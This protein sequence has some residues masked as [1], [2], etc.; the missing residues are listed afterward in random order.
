MALTGTLLADF[1][2]FNDAVKQAEVHLKSFETGAGGV[3]K[4]LN[5][6]VD[7][8]SGRKLIQDA[9]QMT[10]AIDR[11]GGASKLTANE[12]AKVNAQVTEAIAKFGALGQSAPE[13]MRK[14][15][16]QTKAIEPAMTLG[17]KA[18][19]FLKSS[20]GKLGVAMAGAFA[21]TKVFELGKAFVDLT[22]NLAD[23][24]AKTGIGT[25]ALQK[26]K[27]A[28]EQNG[29]SLEQVTAA[30]G[31]MGKRLV[32]G[33]KS[34]VGG[35]KQLGLSL[36]TVRAMKPDDA[37]AAIADAIAKVPDPMGQ[38]ALAMGLFG[39]AGADMLPM[40]KGNMRELADQ[41]EKLGLVLSEDAVKA[42]DQFGDTLGTLFTAGMALAGQVLAPFLPLL[43]KLA[44]VA[45]VA[46]Q[47]FGT[48]LGDAITVVTF[49]GKKAIDFLV[50]MGEK[51]L[52]F[53][54][55]IPGMSSVVDGAQAAFG[56]LKDA[57]H[58]VGEKIDGLKTPTVQATATL[59][60]MKPV[61]TSLTGDTNKL[62][63]EMRKLAEQ[64]SGTGLLTEARKYEQLLGRIGGASKLTADEKRKFVTVF[65]DVI[66]KYRVIG[67]AEGQRVVA[68]FQAVKDSLTV[69]LQPTRTYVGMLGELAPA[70]AHAN[71]A[72]DSYLKGTSLGTQLMFEYDAAMRR[73]TNAIA[74]HATETQKALKHT[75]AWSDVIK[76]SLGSLPDLVRKALTGGGGLIGGLQAMFSDLG[77]SIT[78]KLFG[79]E[80]NLGKSLTGGLTK[81]FG[82]TIGGAVSAIIP[83]LGSL[84]GPL[85]GKIGSF[86]GNLFGKGEHG[87]VNDL[88]D[89]FIS[90]AG[91]L[92][93][94][95]VKAVEAGTSLDALL[96]AKK[97]KD[98]EAAVADLKK[99]IGDF[100][101]A[102]EA[103]T[104]R[105]SAAM[106]HYGLSWEQAGEKMRQAE[107]NR[108]AKEL[109]ENFRVL[110]KVGGFEVSAV[111]E[112][113]TADANAFIQSALR[114]GT[115]IPS[116]M[117]PMLQQ[118]VDMGALIDASG[119]KLESLE[120]LTFATSLTEGFANV[121]DAINGLKDAITGLPA[122][123]GRAAGGVSDA[124]GNIRVPNVRIPVTFDVPGLP[125]A[126]SAETFHAGGMV[127]RKGKVLPFPRLHGGL[128][129][130]EVPAILQT[131]EAV[132]NR[133]AAGM[134]GASAI[135]AL[136]RGSAAGGPPVNVT[137]QIDRPRFND[138]Q[139]MEELGT[140]VERVLTQRLSNRLKLGA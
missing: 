18:T 23:L 111:L 134:L 42:G 70:L 79:A 107:I 109:T 100:A 81:M 9:T 21:V 46:A 16:E 73:T 49:V 64:F 32:E 94:L 34:A 41:A 118:M 95:N 83:G 51:V 6:M 98:F 119:M 20:V 44:D 27:F 30:V 92:H 58:W 43:Q 136:N 122:V 82:S 99:K 123:A 89:Q 62:G 29:G 117:K 61:V 5:R 120:G 74:E 10:E 36:E 65:G 101:E 37:F 1:S 59:G 17:A 38:S 40:M 103:D 105:L 135:H 67:G 68:H 75:A 121:V 97:V 114:T 50:R 133:R 129:P 106:E 140:I 127:D 132:L 113:M 33:D 87:K 125:S 3:E 45:L 55:K 28:A 115:E 69:A 31:Q 14:L 7:S 84:L 39:K 71:I 63:N 86:F 35:L 130:D 137:I 22:G 8:F 15:A 52:A 4:S 116:A 25:T 13:A 78:G 77:A 47:A 108:Q 60:N 12:K 57:A 88:R 104:E 128:G 53:A 138:R 91:G 11:L 102:T 2:K 24:S 131:G 19:D 112:K 90:A 54:Q 110:T 66:E 80:S 85:A 48:V 93:E 26:L 76:K 72:Q 124:L 96:R 126:P 56:G 139:D